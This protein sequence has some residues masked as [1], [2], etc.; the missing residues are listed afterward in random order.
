MANWCSTTIRLVG[1]PEEMKKVYDNMRD[2]LSSNPMKADFDNAW[3]GNLLLHIGYT[4]E[5][6]RNG[7]GPRCRG[8]VTD[9]DL[10]DNTVCVW[11]ETAWTP[12]VRC[13][14]EFADRYAQSF[15]LF[16]TAEEPGCEL[17]LTNDPD[18]VGTVVIDNMTDKVVC[19]VSP[20]D[21]EYVS[22]EF[23]RGAMSEY[24]K[25]DGTFEE[26]AREMLQTGEDVSIHVFERCDESEVD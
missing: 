15:K 5:Q 9:L 11:T 16:F 13:I 12:M 26:L 19:G 1:E 21:M 17:F 4:P 24:L 7:D 10:T 23:A 8:S 2:A 6:I 20:Y 3:M 22:A 18:D 25:K 14:R